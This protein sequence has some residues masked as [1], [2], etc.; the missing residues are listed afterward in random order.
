MK[1]YTVSQFVFALLFGIVLLGADVMAGQ[2]KTLNTATLSMN[3]QLTARSSPKNTANVMEMEVYEFQTNPNGGSFQCRITQNATGQDLNI[4]LIGVNG[5][6][7][8]SCVTPVNGTCDTP[9]VSLVGNLKFQCLVSTDAFSAVNASAN[10]TM[11][12]RRLGGALSASSS[13]NAEADEAGV[14]AY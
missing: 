11:A 5:T 1:R 8:S 12:V 4:R 6:V 9:S 3:S 7:I 10:Y 14:I 13:Q 2:Y